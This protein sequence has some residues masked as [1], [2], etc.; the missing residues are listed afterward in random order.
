MRELNE[1]DKT[2]LSEDAAIYGK[3]DDREPIE[4]FKS[5]KGEEKR[6]YF[7]DYMLPKIIG[8][9]IGL[10][11]LVFFLVSIL[12][13]KDEIVLH[14]AILDSPFTA[15]AIDSLTESLTSSLTEEGKRQRVSLDTEYYISSDG[16]NSRT[17]LMTYIAAGEIDCMILS[18]EELDN[19][20]GSGFY[21]D[22]YTI[23]PK[24]TL[25]MIKDDLVY[26]PTVYDEGEEKADPDSETCYA[27]NITKGINAINGFE[28]NV[29]YYMVCVLNTKH[30]D[31]FDAITKLFYT[32]SAED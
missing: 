6:Q 18:E 11:C 19:Y 22:L 16:Y 5:L 13:P 29:D 31:N 25:A 30:P 8:L 17:R 2:T 4:K 28:L 7:K 3:R 12:K 1:K 10:G 23:L 27:V 26:L 9:V 24:E 15:E 20:S 32:I 21:A 14:A